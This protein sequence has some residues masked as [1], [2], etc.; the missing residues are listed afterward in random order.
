MINEFCINNAVKD[1]MRDALIDFRE[2]FNESE[3]NHSC[4]FIKDDLYQYDPCEYLF[5]DHGSFRCCS[6]YV[7]SCPCDCINHSIIIEIV[8][9]FLEGE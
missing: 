1:K 4:P 5:A 6:G 3:R 9:N 7:N 8:D 2:K